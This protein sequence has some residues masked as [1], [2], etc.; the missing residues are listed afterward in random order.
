M[1]K[2]TI[3]N[4]LHIGTIRTAGTTPQSALQLRRFLLT[5]LERMLGEID[6]DLL[7]NGD[8]FDKEVVPLAD[9]QE[10][11]RIF[12]NWLAKGKKLVLA[13]GN[14]DL[15][16]NSSIKSVFQFFSKLMV[17]LFPGRVQHVE[18][19]TEIQPGYWVLPHLANQDLLNDRLSRVPEAK[20]LFVHTNYA[21][22]FAVQSDHSL[23]IS[24]EQISECKAEVVVFGHEH[25]TKTAMAGRVFI[26][27]NQTPSSISDCIGCQ[28]D[29]KF[30]TVINDDDKPELVAFA[31][32]D[33]KEVDW[34]QLSD[35]R[36]V[37][38][39]VRVGGTAVPDEGA[40][41]AQTIARFRS[42]CEAYV[43]TNAVQMQ[44]SADAVEQFAESLDSVQRFDV[45]SALLEL[46]NEEEGSA[47][48]ELLDA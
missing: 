29:T 40:Q 20:L 19:L 26:P 6:T 42:S 15:P 22:N 33:F 37:E 39:F 16:K 5:E 2:L 30:Y 36:P 24:P 41:V 23:N 14:H 12:I 28:A 17:S 46:L 43:V 35:T 34:R 32:T 25:Q 4:D 27:G 8:L 21:N 47:V 9:V 18:D 7:V 3:I 11:L 31:P 38:R 48:K 10:C 45:L 1:A 13:G 44:T